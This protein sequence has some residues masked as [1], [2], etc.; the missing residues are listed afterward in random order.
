MYIHEIDR[1][2]IHDNNTYWSTKPFAHCW[3]GLLLLQK[4]SLPYNAASKRANPDNA[5]GVTLPLKI[6]R[7]EDLPLTI[8]YKVSQA[9]LKPEAFKGSPSIII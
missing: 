6:D 1:L 3:K 9:K 2:F 5:T 7:I 8:K 4:N